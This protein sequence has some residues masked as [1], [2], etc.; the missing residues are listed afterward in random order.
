[1]KK[2]LIFLIF[3]GGCA[4]PVTHTPI[5]EPVR[6]V[7]LDT[8][9]V[10]HPDSGRWFECVQT[11]DFYTRIDTVQVRG[12]MGNNLLLINGGELKCTFINEIAN[13]NR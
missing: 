11:A 9:A 7:V 12:R 3:V 4:A 13:G 10:T 2:L 6:V 5:P 8:V 1:M